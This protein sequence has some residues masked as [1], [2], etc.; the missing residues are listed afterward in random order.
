M[1]VGFIV[2]TKK[3]RKNHKYYHGNNMNVP[4]LSLS[5]FVLDGMWVTDHFTFDLADKII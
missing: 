5:L 3:S 1:L 4:C 2:V